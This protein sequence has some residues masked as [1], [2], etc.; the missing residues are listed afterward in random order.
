MYSISSNSNND[1]IGESIEP[2]TSM[3]LK[4]VYEKVKKEQQKKENPKIDGKVVFGKSYKE[5][6]INKKKNKKK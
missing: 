2:E 5:P 4:K 6:K 3:N 1:K